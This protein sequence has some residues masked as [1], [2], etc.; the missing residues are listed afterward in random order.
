MRELHFVIDS[1]EPGTV[2]S[3]LPKMGLLRFFQQASSCSALSLVQAVCL[4][5]LLKMF[6]LSMLK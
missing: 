3:A 4:Q 5:Y 2:F 1:G 6:R